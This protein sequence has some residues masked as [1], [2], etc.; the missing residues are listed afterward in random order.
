MYVHM[1]FIHTNKQFKLYKLEIITIY[2]TE[3]TRI[4][5]IKFYLQQHSVIITYF[6]NPA[7]HNRAAD[8]PDGQTNRLT[9]NTT[10]RMNHKMKMHWLTKSYFYMRVCTNECK[11]KKDVSE[12]VIISFSSSSSAATTTTTPT[13]KSSSLFKLWLHFIN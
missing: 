1:C 6:N 7:Q 4:I 13:T 10:Q 9:N 3:V 12:W 11:C 8:R 2:R 5:V